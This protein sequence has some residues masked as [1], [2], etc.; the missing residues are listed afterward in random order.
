MADEPLADQHPSES[1]T[2][3][4]TPDLSPK[5]RKELV[6][7]IL[8]WL[9]LGFIM[10]IYFAQFNG[11]PIIIWDLRLYPSWDPAGAGYPAAHVGAAGVMVCLWFIRKMRLTLPG[12]VGG[13]MMIIVFSFFGWYFST[14][15]LDLLFRPS[16]G[17]YPDLIIGT[18]MLVSVFYLSWLYWGPV[19]PGLGLL[20]IAYLFIAD[21]LPGPLKGPS[22]DTHIIISRQVTQSVNQQVTILAASFLWMLVFWGL[23]LNDLGG[24]RALMALARK[25]SQGIAG[26]PAMG[27]LITSALTGS[28][29]GGG[30]SNVAITGPVT[31]PAMRSAGYTSEEAGSVEAMASNASSIT[32]PILG[33]VAFVMADLLRVSY[34]DIIIMSLIPATLWFLAVG[35]WIVTHAQTNRH[36]I[37][38]I[39]APVVQTTG[40]A[41]AWYYAR[42]TLVLAIP[43]AS[44]VILVVQAYTLKRAAFTAFLI[45]IILALV[46]RVEKNYRVVWLNAFRN[47]AMYAS[48]ITVIIVIVALIA[49]TLVFTGLGGRLGNVIEA[50]SQGQLV[51]AAA[52]MVVAG[53]ILGGPLPALPVYFIMVVTFVPVLTKMGVPQIATHYVAFYMGALGSITLPVAASCL[54]AAAIA[55]TKYWPT[56]VVTAKVS[57][58]LW[59]YPVL[60]ALAPEL[61]L[62][63]D[64]GP[65]MTWLIIGAAAVVMIGVQSATGGW[66]VR[67]IPVPL[68]AVLYANFGLLVVTLLPQFDSYRAPMLI[69]AMGVVV[70]VAVILAL[71]IGR[72]MGS[73]GM[74]GKARAP[75]EAEESSTG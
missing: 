62:Q 55:G 33:A 3:M 59:V 60:F 42:S 66:L 37:K 23:L 58:P 17:T 11:I 18:A 34:I 20:F 29:V 69:A 28:F 7:D 40:Y 67:S 9:S 24:G 13:I 10:L 22:L 54:V 4:G 64:S 38:P 68:R 72:V 15:S 2:E 21:L 48:S 56:A 27:S 19:F 46:L 14:N 51:I 30:A 73:I 50:A 25:L 39:P 6:L 31:I 47:A 61:L 44:I 45:T 43:V 1:R 70:V 57:W 16:Y 75:A 36:R 74:D 32:P 26:G 12:W 35:A 41:A 63:G 71:G 53:V 8:F 49:D 65:G 5:T 52:I